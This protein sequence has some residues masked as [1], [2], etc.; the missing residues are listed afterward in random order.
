[1][2]KTAIT[3]SMLYD[4]VRCPHR[5]T[6]DLFADPAE[7]DPVSPFLQLLWE[8]GQRFEEEFVE[9]L[10]VPR[11]DLR[12]GSDEDRERLTLEAMRA[13]KSL[14]YGG[15]IRAVDLLGEPD[16]LK[17]Q[18]GGYVAGDIKSGSGFEGAGEES[19][20][21]PK[22]PYA[23]QLAFYTDILERLGLSGG[24][25]P[26][27]WD[28]RRQEVQYLLDSPRG[29]RS[30]G[31]LWEEYRSSLEEV[32][33]I[34]AGRLQTLPALGS[35]CK[36]CW[37]RTTCTRRIEELDDLTLIPE[38]GRTRRDQLAA[39]FRTVRELA[40]GDLS[41]LTA[42]GTTALPGIGADLLRRFQARAR[43]QSRRGSN[44]YLIEELEL[45]AL[46]RE[47]FFDVET[48][49]MRGLCYLHG[50]V[51][52][53]GGDLGTERYV[54]FFAGE[55]TGEAEAEAFAQAWAYIR[56]LRPTALY[57][58]SPYERTVW[59]ALAGRYPSVAGPQQVRELFAASIAV[60]LY[61]DVV[62][63]KTEWPTRD[64]SIKT[65][66]KFLGFRWRD[67]EPSGAASIEWYHRWVDSGDVAVKGRILAYNE[68]DCLAMRVLADAVRGMGKSEHAAGGG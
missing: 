40:R 36:L 12:A 41:A 53:K 43:L 37:W 63:T 55:P 66:A 49:P 48:D 8:S 54:P 17:R 46:D 11:V 30:Q 21:R 6:M 65:L 31:T 23:M 16:L 61:Q 20:G 19:E 42:R 27:V 47:L 4:F 59:G 44:P 35:G 5:V 68:D 9:G 52:R 60:D 25:L 10:E 56:E 28:I 26:F 15:R 64:L 67:A 14:I 34:A 62:R 3:A 39:Y 57:Y 50:F 51:E 32:R 29:A 38:L 58:Y 18:G 13:G 45:P 7:K 24:R 2:R 22:K 33:S 1:M